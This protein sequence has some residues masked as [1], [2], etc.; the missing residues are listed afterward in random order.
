MRS[1]IKVLFLAC[2]ASCSPS[3]RVEKKLSPYPKAGV[4]E[5]LDSRLKSPDKTKNY[6]LLL[7]PMSGRG[8]S[9]GK[10]ALNACLLA[11]GDSKNVKFY[12]VDTADDS[13]E[14][15]ALRD[16]FKA[17]KFVIG[18][19]FSYEAKQYGA[20]FPNAA[21]LS[22]S[23]DREINGDHVFACGLSVE[24]EI[25]ALAKYANA[26]KINS[27]LIMLPEGESGDQILKVIVAELK[28]YGF[29]EGDDLEIIRY[30]DI[31]RKAATK[32]AKNS[33]KKA[34]FAVNP[35]L[36]ISKLNNTAVFTTS[37]AALSN[38]ETW[39]GAI[40][41]FADNPKLQEFVEKYKAA[42]GTSPTT[43][44][45]VV[46]DLLESINESVDSGE[47][48]IENNYEGCLGEFSID[49]KSGLKRSL[50]VFRMENSQKVELNAEQE[51]EQE[52]EEEED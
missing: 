47:P 9:I 50:Q 38:V 40:F 52:K 16:R 3:K 30:G 13:I 14:K 19:A 25:Q 20:L 21:I 49:K 24:D 18:P 33:G 39:N 48:L 1:L 41:A 6:A 11:A 44:D 46:Y 26:Q 2:L 35:I 5:L 8:E 31:S 4:D 28:K 43:L 32:Y 36:D 37:S 17:P 7:L 22:L 29:E 23:N 51:A 45:I 12:V 10:G 42:F 34:V 27:F 15:F